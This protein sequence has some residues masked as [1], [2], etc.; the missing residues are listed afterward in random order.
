[1]NPTRLYFRYLLQRTLFGVVGLFAVIWLLV[2]SVDLVEAMR[3]VGK[4]QD[5]GFSEAIRMTLFRTPQLLLTLSPFVFLFGTLWAFGQMSKS[6]EIAVMRAA[7]L[8][9]WRIVAAPV[10]LAILAGIVT[11]LVFDPVAADLSSRAQMI[12][13]EMRGKRANMLE[14]FRDGIWLRQVDGNIASILRADR[15]DPD[16]QILEGVT[17]WRRTADE[18][19]FLDRWDAPL[20]QVEPTRFI[21]QDVKRTTL[22]HEVEPVRDREIFPISIDLRALR[23]DIA[24]PESLSVWE[25]PDFTDV[26]SSAGMST[27][28]YELRYQELLSLP[29]RLAAMVLIACAFALG[30]NARAGG[31]AVLMGIGIATGFALFILSEF[32]TAIARAS[33]VPIQI[34]SWAPSMLAIVFAVTL[35]LYREDG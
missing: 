32:S 7:G 17:I 4:V 11:M 2:V 10:V 29:F 16:E 19:V 25:L 8:S 6:S 21:L 33:I 24:Q 23:E 5:A 12:K 15:Y 27:I 26:M 9:V 14:P 18:G 3:E 35:L 31:T 30:M 1:M 28:R 34:A 20:G 22:L 13:N